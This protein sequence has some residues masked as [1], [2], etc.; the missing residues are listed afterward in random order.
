MNND[1]IIRYVDLTELR[2]FATKEE[3]DS[4]CRDAIKHRCASICIPPSYVKYVK[5]KYGSKTSI[6]TVIGF[7]LGYQTTET[8]L[9]EVKNA[10]MDGADEL[11]VV[12]NIG[13][14]KDKDYT[15]VA[16]ELSLIK[17]ASEKQVLKVI[18]ETC[19]LKEE[20]IINLCKIISEL[21][22]DYIKTSTGFGTAGANLND[23][24]VMKHNL[25]N[26]VKI[27]AAGGIKNKEQMEEYINEGCQRLGSSSA[28]KALF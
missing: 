27:K 12:V 26:G 7:P 3:I 24:R 11:D 16:K 17:E 13:K 4:L 20:E 23:I 14:V 2:P 22:I 5:S 6:C 8:K 9:Y 19:Y 1:E 25:Y 21:K 18:I 15:F 28:V 10:V